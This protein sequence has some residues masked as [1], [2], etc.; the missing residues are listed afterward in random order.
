M[1]HSLMPEPAQTLNGLPAPSRFPSEQHFRPAAAGPGTKRHFFNL[2]GAQYK[3]SVGHVKNF[4][5]IA[6]RFLDEASRASSRP[7][8]NEASNSWSV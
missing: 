6:A 7:G 5:H 3:V 1:R 8:Q 2:N 4:F